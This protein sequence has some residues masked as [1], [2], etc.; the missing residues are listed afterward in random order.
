MRSVGYRQAWDYLEGRID[1]LALRCAGQAASRQLA[2][3]QMTWL[4]QLP[5]DAA[6]DPQQTGWERAALDWARA[7]GV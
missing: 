4:R 7:S 1:E 3:R 2:K 6:L 5:H